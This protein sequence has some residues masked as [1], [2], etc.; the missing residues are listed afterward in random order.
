[1]HPTLSSNCSPTNNR[2]H[3]QVGEEV[4][5]KHQIQGHYSG[6]NIPG[7]KDFLGRI[8]PILGVKKTSCGLRIMGV[9]IY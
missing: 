4:T 7:K 2:T 6:K 1:M 8:I 9:R 5:I 3:Y